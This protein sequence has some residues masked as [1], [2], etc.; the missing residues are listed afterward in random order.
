MK[1]KLLEK[2]YEQTSNDYYES[3]YT[4]YDVY[5][6]ALSSGSSSGG[7]C[8]CIICLAILGAISGEC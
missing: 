7:C 8:G 5:E 2:Y 3:S 1:N 6:V 4:F